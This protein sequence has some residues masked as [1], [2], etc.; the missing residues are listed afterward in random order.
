MKI[1]L[2]LSFHILLVERE[3]QPGFLV[4]GIMNDVVDNHSMSGWLCV[5]MK[6]G[7]I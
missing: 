1:R 6:H 5:G 3:F 2:F 7:G 4:L